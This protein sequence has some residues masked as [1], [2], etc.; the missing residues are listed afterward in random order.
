M[1]NPVVE[2]KNLEI[3]Y[4]KT[5]VLKDISFSVEPGEIFVILG[6][7]GCGKS[8]LLKHII[9]LYNPF[10]GEILIYG[11]SIVKADENEK[12]RM[13][14]SFGVTYQGGALFGSLTVG[15][16]ISLV[17]EEHTNHSKDEIDKIVDEKL[18]LVDM[19]KFRN[20]M[21]SEISGGMRKRA[22]I[23]RAMAL[24][25]KLLFFDEPSAGLDPITSAELDRLILDLSKKSGATMVIVTHELDSIFTVADRVIMLDS[26]SKTM[27]AEG[28]P[29]TLLENPP[30]PRVKEFLTRSGLKRK[31]YCD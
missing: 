5:V 26:N 25:P 19:D 11:E 15:E 9:G 8:T 28:K 31:H 20:Y 30:I 4:D 3:G 21:P 10:K 22:G 14:K 1:E 18:S 24:D 7:S 6:G 29:Q 17:L 12:R 13:M 16:N 27:V 2:V 23:A